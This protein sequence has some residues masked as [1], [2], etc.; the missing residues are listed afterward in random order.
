MIKP[1]RKRLTVAGLYLWAVH[2]TNTQL[3]ITT[4]RKSMELAIKKARKVIAEQHSGA[5]I[6]EVK[7][8]GT[9]DL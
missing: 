8:H 9:I 3:W 7:G 5:E 4:R 6:R 2:I 1:K